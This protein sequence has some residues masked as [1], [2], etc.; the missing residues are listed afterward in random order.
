[1]TYDLDELK[2]SN[3][4]TNSAKTIMSLTHTKGQFTQ[5]IL[6]ELEAF[7]AVLEEHDKVE[8]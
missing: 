2:I 6:E 5:G 3:E 4:F 1:M 7:L 8:G